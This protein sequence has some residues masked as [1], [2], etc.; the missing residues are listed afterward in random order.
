MLTIFPP[1][2][3]FGFGFPSSDTRTGVGEVGAVKRS[4]LRSR[5]RCSIAGLWIGSTSFLV[6]REVFSDELLGEKAQF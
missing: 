2:A 3:L 5:E 4:H 1:N 6:H